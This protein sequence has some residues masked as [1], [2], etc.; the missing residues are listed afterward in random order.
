MGSPL[1]PVVANLIMEK[2]EQEALTQL[3][4]NNISLSTYRR[5]VDME[6]VVEQ[7]NAIDEKLKFTVEEETEESLRFLDLTLTRVGEKIQKIW[8]PK[9]REKKI[10]VTEKYQ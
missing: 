6:K 4:K 5:Y 2:V 9:Q 3:E 7:F 1:S 8:F 10:P